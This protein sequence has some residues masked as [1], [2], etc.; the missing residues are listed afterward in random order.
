MRDSGPDTRPGNDLRVDADIVQLD[1]VVDCVIKE[2]D[3]TRDTDN[4]QGLC[5]EERKDKGSQSGGK[6]RFVDAKVSACPAAHVELEGK[7]W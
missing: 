6:Q 1:D 3:E 7:C 5:G 2:G 4:S